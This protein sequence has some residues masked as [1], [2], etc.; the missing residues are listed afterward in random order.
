MDESSLSSQ[1]EKY[2]EYEILRTSL[3]HEYEHSKIVKLK[4]IQLEY[5][6]RQTAR[7]EPSRC[8][9]GSRLSWGTRVKRRFW[10]QHKVV[11]GADLG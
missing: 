4:C 10:F 11:W 6:V 7:T 9:K 8:L 1:K 5:A 3:A 2:H